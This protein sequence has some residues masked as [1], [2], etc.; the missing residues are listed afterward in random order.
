[1]VFT[2]SSTLPIDPVNGGYSP[3]SDVLGFA[4]V[5]YDMFADEYSDILD[6]PINPPDAAPLPWE[7]HVHF[8]PPFQN[9]R[10]KWASFYTGSFYFSDGMLPNY[11]PFTTLNVVAHEMGHATS[12]TNSGILCYDDEATT[13]IYESFSDMTAEAAESFLYG[14]CDY[15][16]GSRVRITS[17]GYHRNMLNPR[18]ACYPNCNDETD[19]LDHVWQYWTNA[20]N[21]TYIPQD[22]HNVEG[23]YNKVFSTLAA[24]MNWGVEKTYR[25]FLY[26]N[27]TYWCAAS[28]GCE[29][30]DCFYNTTNAAFDSI[31]DFGYTDSDA[32]DLQTAFDEVGAFDWHYDYCTP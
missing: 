16:Q 23:I 9:N 27:I 2:F 22:P 11:H 5:V 7:Y 3:A 30:Y 18:E 12:S 21:I 8:S 13:G 4:G 25:L 28:D 20:T 14:E 29:D 15:L 31:Y 19:P 24:S 32:C 26:T 17:P 6:E 1:L 10:Y